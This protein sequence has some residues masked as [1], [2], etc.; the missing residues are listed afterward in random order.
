MKKLICVILLCLIAVPVFAE[1]TDKEQDYLENVYLAVKNIGMGSNIY[2]KTWYG[3]T[4]KDGYNVKK[5]I[6]RG[7]DVQKITLIKSYIENVD[8]Q[9]SNEN[10]I[11]YNSAIEKLEANIL[12]KQTW[13]DNN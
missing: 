2:L 13:V 3:Q 6:L 9:T 4:I 12:L 8:I 11:N 1:L 7:T 5:I 10:I